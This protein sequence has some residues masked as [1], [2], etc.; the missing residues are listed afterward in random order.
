M[1]SQLLTLFITP[2]VYMWF[3]GLSGWIS[4]RG[5]AAEPVPATAAAGAA[6]HS[7]PAE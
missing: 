6:P 7:Q 1:V 5:S 2:V 4:R 3:D